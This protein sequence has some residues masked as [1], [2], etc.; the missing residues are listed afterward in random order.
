MKREL[1]ETQA[2]GLSGAI[3]C[4]L[5]AV[6]SAVACAWLHDFYPKLEGFATLTGMGA[7]M[8]GFAAVACLIIGFGGTP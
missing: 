4:G 6:A 7:F 2:L 8:L 5:L 1:T 3:C